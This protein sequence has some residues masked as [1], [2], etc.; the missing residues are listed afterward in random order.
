MSGE[1][2][3]LALAPLETSY[4]ELSSFIASPRRTGH[5]WMSK[6]PSNPMA[7]LM[8]LCIT[9]GLT[10]RDADLLI[11]EGQRRGGPDSLPQKLIDL[12]PQIEELRALVARR[13]KRTSHGRSDQH[14]PAAAGASREAPAAE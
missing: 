9:L 5:R 13:R 6:G 2:F 7:V 1:T 12:Q 8:N 11:Q 3:T 14:P 10:L 4:A